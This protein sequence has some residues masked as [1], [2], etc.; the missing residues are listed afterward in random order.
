M[1]DGAIDWAAIEADPRFQIL[2]RRKARFLAGLMLVSVAYFF[3]L[4]TCAAWYPELFRIR[5]AGAVNVGILF[6]LSEFL[7][8]WLVAAVYLR[9]ANREFD[10]LTAEINAEIMARYR[11]RGWQ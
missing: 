9:R 1:A 4:P 10:H 7:V 11:Q 6:A 5:V 2:H 8:A 3:L